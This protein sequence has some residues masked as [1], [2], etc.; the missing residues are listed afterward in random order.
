MATVTTRCALNWNRAALCWVLDIYDVND[1]PILQGVPLV[2]G[3]DLL[4]QFAYL[5]LEGQLLAQT[6]HA[7]DTPP[8]YDNLG[9]AGHLYFLPVPK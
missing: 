8:T 7:T 6:D 1:V 2:C 3:A 5:G 9:L 4:E